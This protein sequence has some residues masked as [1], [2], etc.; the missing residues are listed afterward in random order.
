MY[1]IGLL[2]EKKFESAAQQILKTF[3]R[4][5]TSAM[6]QN[7]TLKRNATFGLAEVAEVVLLVALCPPPTQIYYQTIYERAYKKDF[8]RS[9]KK[10]PN[11]F[12]SYNS[13]N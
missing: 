5:A 7:K 13:D 12:A 9:I 6:F 1:R 2:T 3:V 4:N 8:V 11:A 10:C